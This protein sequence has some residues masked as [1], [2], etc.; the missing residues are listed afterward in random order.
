P[1]EGVSSV[2]ASTPVRSP[3]AETPH[4]TSP[5]SSSVSA[6]GDSKP[7]GTP[8]SDAAASNDQNVQGRFS[9]QAAAFPTEAAADEFAEKLKQA[10]VPSYVVNADLARRGRWFRVRIGRFNTAEDAQRYSSEAQLRARASG[11]S[12]QLIVCQYEQP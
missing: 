7:S 9:L 1:T 11:T 10:G 4:I 2:L 5:A 6:A 3:A 8:A 12:L